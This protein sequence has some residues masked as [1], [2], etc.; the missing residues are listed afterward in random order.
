MFIFLPGFPF[1]AFFSLSVPTQG[2]LEAFPFRLTKKSGPTFLPF[3]VTLQPFP[4][5]FPPPFYDRYLWRW[6][7][8]C[9]FG[10]PPFLHPSGPLPGHMVTFVAN[11]FW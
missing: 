6:P 10:L 3:C 9:S 11:V 5:P 7:S 2:R 8:V 4:I 1:L